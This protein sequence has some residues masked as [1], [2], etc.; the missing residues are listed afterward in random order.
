MDVERVC[1]R[2]TVALGETPVMG[3]PASQP[4]HT[5]YWPADRFDHHTVPRAGADARALQAR[6][7]ATPASLA[8]L[9]GLGGAAHSVATA[10]LD[11]R[12][13]A[14]T[15]TRMKHEAPQTWLVHAVHDRLRRRLAERAVADVRVDFEDGYGVRTD[16]A[17]D[18]D[19]DRVG[20]ALARAVGDGALCARAGVRIKAMTP[21]LYPR[22]RRTLSRVLARLGV[23]GRWPET[24]VLTVPKVTHAEQAAVAD[25]L[26]SALEQEHGRPPGSLRLEVMVET[27]E[28]LVAADGRNPL[29]AIID[30]AVPRLLGVHLGVYD[31]TAAMRVP[32]GGQAPDHPHCAR[33]RSMMRLAA[34]G[35]V[36]LSDG[37]SN[38]IPAGTDAAVRR[39]WQA[40]LRHVMGALRD[41]YVQG[42][43]M[44]PGQ[45]V[46]RHL[47]NILF[48]L[49]D[50]DDVAAR[51]AALLKTAVV[52]S[53]A[54]TVE[55]AVLDE[56]A[57]GRA[58]LRAVK[59]GWF[60]GALDDADLAA[61]GLGPGDLGATSFAALVTR[62]QARGVDGSEGETDG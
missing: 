50:Y 4:V 19:A 51:L 60:V 42:W 39:A 26:L 13:F 28:S 61:A 15:P 59:R 33:A 43:D 44:H 52:A 40:N 22:A 29:P 8:S 24:F 48:W 1:A 17:E 57:T 21:E 49:R 25:A 56:P 12:R 20:D 7:L 27:H 3:D 23:H 9:C 53:G 6:L 41:G 46:M 14:E 58:L 36:H 5:L 34:G 35:R 38:A 54:Q 47:G 62:R 55:G 11:A 45:L 18:R 30:A 32:P 2:L 10:R 37:A 31:F 16:A